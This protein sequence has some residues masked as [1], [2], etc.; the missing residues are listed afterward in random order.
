[1]E[2]IPFDQIVTFEAFPQKLCWC[3]D[4]GFETVEIHRMPTEGERAMTGRTTL[5]IR[6]FGIQN[7]DAFVRLFN[8][9]KADSGIAVAATATA[10]ATSV[11]MI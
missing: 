4:A 6:L 7:A 10:P 1:L 2:Q 3:H 5:R 11:E 9:L 8:V